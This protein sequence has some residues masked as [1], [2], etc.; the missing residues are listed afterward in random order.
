[1]YKNVDVLEYVSVVGTD[2]FMDFVDSIKNEGVDI[3]KK[4]MG[5]RTEPKAPLVIEVDNENVKKDIEK[6]NIQIP[7]LTPRIYREY[8]NISQLSTSEFK[9]KKIKLKN[10]SK[11]E[12]REIIFK[13]ITSG[14]VPIVPYWV[15]IIPNA[16]SINKS[17]FQF[18][19]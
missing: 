8:K 15:S 16:V 1:M 18:E 2:A 19:F 5:E 3:E 11:K 12:K 17:L 6:L 13:D 14:K 4:K 7:I 9:H 10:F